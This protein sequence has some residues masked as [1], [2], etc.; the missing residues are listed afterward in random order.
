MQL[1]LKATPN[2][3]RK[4]PK[5]PKQEEILLKQHNRC[6]YCGFKFYGFVIWQSKLIYLRPA[7]DHVIPFIFTQTNQPENFVA[8]CK[9][10]NSIKSS[11]HFDTIQERIT[12]VRNTRIEKGLPVSE[13]CGDVSTKNEVAEVLFSE[14]SKRHVLDLAQSRCDLANPNNPRPFANWTLQELMQ[15]E[16]AA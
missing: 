1:K 12:Y 9:T 4:Q 7:F 13:M 11:K 2:T 15:F 14:V 16:A 10:C 5:K 6:Y 8:A 3:F